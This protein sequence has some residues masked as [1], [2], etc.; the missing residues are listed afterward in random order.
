M[1]LEIQVYIRNHQL[2][3]KCPCQ[4]DNKGNRAGAIWQ[5][6][7]Y[8]E[9]NRIANKID[10]GYRCTVCDKDISTVEKKK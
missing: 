8:G 2:I 7:T 3:K 1:D 5:S 10:T 9:G 6:A 4:S